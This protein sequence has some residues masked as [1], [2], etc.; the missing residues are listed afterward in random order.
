M[1]DLVEA[2]ASGD[3]RRTLEE[4]RDYLARWL[5]DVEPKNAAPLAKQLAD[6]VRELSEMPA[7]E[8]NPLDAL[9]ARRSDRLSRATGS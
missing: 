6:V 1:P 7:T 4:L 5:M 2:A 8:A 9:A 3:R